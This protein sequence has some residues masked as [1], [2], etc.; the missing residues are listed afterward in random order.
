MHYYVTHV[1]GLGE[2]VTTELSQQLP[3]AVVL[4]SGHGQLQLTYPGPPADLLA[5]RTIEHLCVQVAALPT[6]RPEN[7]WLDELT[8][9]M[10]SLDL[11]PALQHLH[12]V[13]PLPL[14]PRFRVTAQRQGDHEFRSPTLA[15]AAGAGVADR[16]GWPVDLT[17]YDLDVRIEVSGRQ[18]L[19]GL[20]LSETALHR[21]SRIVHTRASLNPTVAAAMVLLSKPAGGET[22]IDPMCGAGTLI[23]ERE[24]CLSGARLLAGDLFAEKLAMTLQNLQAFH[25]PAAL[26][27]GDAARL[28]FPSATI[29]K[30]LCNPPW[31]RV[32]ASPQINRRLYPQ[33]MRELARCLRPG[34]LAVLLTSERQLMAKCLQPDLPLR[35]VTSYLLSVGGLKPTLYVLR[36]L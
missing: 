8:E 10:A 21:R 4:G 27:Q 16:Y 32:I 24:A 15:G 34:G 14:I 11:G 6:V 30:V 5:L 28:P 13:R 18:G 7:S 3:T 23:V 33:F 20:R 35:T 17:A 25:V 29:D 31:G 1:G 22:V 12:S 26:W 19:V 2:I 36:R 9:W